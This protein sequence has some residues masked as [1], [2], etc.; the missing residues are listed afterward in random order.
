MPTGFL[1]LLRNH[2][3]VI[4]F[5]CTYLVCIPINIDRHDFQAETQQLGFLKNNLPQDWDTSEAPETSVL[6]LLTRPIQKC[7][8]P[9]SIFVFWKVIFENIPNNANANGAWVPPPIDAPWRE[10]F[11]YGLRSAVALSVPGKLFLCDRFWWPIQIYR[12]Y[13]DG[14]LSNVVVWRLHWRAAQSFRRE[15]DER[16]LDDTICRPY[17]AEDKLLTWSIVVARCR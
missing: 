7:G 4:V 2:L 5:A 16:T 8:D 14:G 11:V 9:I 13:F 12:L 10:L 6:E 1:F 17:F 15:L 3:F